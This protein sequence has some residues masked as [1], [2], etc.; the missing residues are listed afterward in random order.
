[1]SGIRGPFCCSCPLFCLKNKTQNLNLGEFVLFKM[2]EDFILIPARVWIIFM[3]SHVQ[4]LQHLLMY[5]SRNGS[6]STIKELRLNLGGNFICLCK[7]RRL[8]LQW[9]HAQDRNFHSFVVV[10]SPFKHVQILLSTTQTIPC[11]IYTSTKEVVG[12]KFLSPASLVSLAS[13]A[14][15]IAG[16]SKITVKRFRHGL[17]LHAYS[18]S[19]CKVLLYESSNEEIVT[20]DKAFH[21]WY[22]VIRKNSV[23]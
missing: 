9:A 4:G 19:R 22:R 5:T 15:L 23:P 18:V 3:V 11:T 12:E 16:G 10:S 13:A 8:K 21:T 20:C 1:V 17:A 2:F 6:V 14:I 7:V